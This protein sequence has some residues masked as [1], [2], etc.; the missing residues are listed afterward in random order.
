MDGVTKTVREVGTD[1][2]EN[3]SISVTVAK[4]QTNCY[5]HYKLQAC[6]Q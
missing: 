4:E 3:L 1:C 5:T 2:N 6:K